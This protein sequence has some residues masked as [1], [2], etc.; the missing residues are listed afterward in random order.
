MQG[1]LKCFVCG[2]T[3]TP[4][5]RRHH[6]TRELLCN[7][8]GV[9]VNNLNANR[10]HTYRPR[11]RRSKRYPSTEVQHQP[12]ALRQ[13]LPESGPQDEHLQA[14]SVPQDGPLQKGAP[15]EAQLRQAEPAAQQA[16]SGHRS[17][18]HA[19]EKER[20]H[21]SSI[22]CQSTMQG[23]SPPEVQLVQAGPAAQQA[24]AGH[25]S[26]Q[27]APGEE[28]VQASSGQRESSMHRRSIPDAQPQQADSGVQQA[29]ADM[30]SPGQPPPRRGDRVK[31]SHAESS[32]NVIATPLEAAREECFQQAGSGRRQP[33]VGWRIP[34]Q[35]YLQAMTALQQ[36]VKQKRTVPQTQPL[37][38]EAGSGQSLPQHAVQGKH[39]NARST[40]RQSAMQ[41]RIFQQLPQTESVGQ[42]AII[43]RPSLK[44]AQ[45]Q[46]PIQ[47]RSLPQVQSQ[48]ADGWEKQATS[49]LRSSHHAL[50]EKQVHASSP[51]ACWPKRKR[52]LPLH[53]LRRAPKKV[54]CAHALRHCANTLS[55]SKAT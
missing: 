8:C 38:A 13:H 10:T 32:P 25:R 6:R 42:Q 48:Q 43:G 54:G 29:E 3:K 47:S 40:P 31:Q 19:L 18:Q 49:G 30:P 11:P 20:F 27:P 44:Y 23:R 34:P 51:P 55:Y 46:R 17:Q 33:K 16:A 14:H 28:H 2:V 4:C 24:G 52:T 53:P 5:W 41:A 21:D 22:P 12:A 39:G 15:P 26:A 37:Q 7:A 50:Q 9:K 1:P 36:W 45:R 35:E